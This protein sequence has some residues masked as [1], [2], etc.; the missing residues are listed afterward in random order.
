M[1]WYFTLSQKEFQSLPEKKDFLI[2]IIPA[3]GV[4]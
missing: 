2:D 4:E 1:Y 3:D